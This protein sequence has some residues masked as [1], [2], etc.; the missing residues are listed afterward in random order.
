MLTHNAAFLNTWSTV[1]TSLLVTYLLSNPSFNGNHQT[2]V[3]L[4]FNCSAMFSDTPNST[5][6]PSYTSDRLPRYSFDGAPPHVIAPAAAAALRPLT[7]IEETPEIQADKQKTL[8]ASIGVGALILIFTIMDGLVF[9]CTW[10]IMAIKLRPWD[11][12]W[13]AEH[14]EKYLLGLWIPSILLALFS[15]F[16]AFYAGATVCSSDKVWKRNGFAGFFLILFFFGLT[17]A[18]FIGSFAIPMATRANYFRHVCD[19][20]DTRIEIDANSTPPFPL[21]KTIQTH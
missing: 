2:P 15:G 14:R 21:V 3:P 5:R 6:P 19:G 7:A 4:S 9:G 20:M 18:P 16:C 12:S 1:S 11:Y 10:F 8:A 13:W 17:F